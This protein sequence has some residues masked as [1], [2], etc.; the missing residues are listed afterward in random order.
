MIRK[1]AA[2]VA[3]LVLMLASGAAGYWLC[4]RQLEEDFLA[5]NV[6]DATSH[7]TFL[8]AAQKKDF[9]KAIKFHNLLFN[10]DFTV[11]S[12][13]L[14][15]RP[16]LDGPAVDNLRLRIAKY[17]DAYPEAVVPTLPRPANP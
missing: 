11:I 5:S 3:V 17:N 4:N 12:Q 9:A 15:D 8:A 7:L 16:D 1:I 6:T 14:R 2:A 10:T 13:L